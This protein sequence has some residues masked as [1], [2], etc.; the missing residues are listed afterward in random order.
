MP[1]IC[2]CHRSSLPFWL[3]PS[4]GVVSDMSA[5]CVPLCY[6]PSRHVA[7]PNEAFSSSCQDGGGGRSSGCDLSCYNVYSGVYHPSSSW[8]DGLDVA[9]SRCGCC[10]LCDYS[11]N[12]LSNPWSQVLIPSVRP[13][14]GEVL[15]RYVGCA[16]RLHNLSRCRN[17][18]QPPFQ[19]V[20]P[21]SYDIC[22]IVK[23]LCSNR[24]HPVLRFCMR[25]IQGMVSGARM[26]RGTGWT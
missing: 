26:W 18:S 20:I 10:G 16:P 12:R 25:F 11:V 9:S 17:N 22:R 23:L 6:I 4:Q 3:R 7:H 19:S 8:R 5:H 15:G 1:H 2:V 13:S 14:Q 24:L 21:R